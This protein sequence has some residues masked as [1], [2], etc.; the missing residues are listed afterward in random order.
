MDAVALSYWS[1]AAAA[2]TGLLFLFS[3]VRSFI[4]PL[5]SRLL[6]GL[7]VGG[8]VGTIGLGVATYVRR[9]VDVGHVP[10][11]TF[12]EALIMAALCT[13]VSFGV[14]YVV[15]GFHRVRGRS[16]ATVDI[17]GLVMC[18][19][20]NLLYFQAHT[21]SSTGETVPPVLDSPYF[22]PHV[23]VMILGYGAGITAAIMGIVFLFMSRGRSELQVETDR[24]L[25][26]IDA[27][28]YRSVMVGFPLLTAGLVLGALWANESWG[29]YWGF[30]S[31]ET[32]ALITWLCFLGYLHLRFVGGW[33][34]RRACWFLALG[35]IVI[36]I[37]FLLF[38]Y[39]PDSV[40]SSQHRYIN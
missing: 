10:T 40:A 14:I 33:R 21:R 18:A 6:H 22:I 24:G 13:E 35:G 37:T 8:L 17:F 2:G 38:G 9:W 12:W 23:S 11:Q 25:Q 20:A 5:A 27:F 3:A 1:Q 39:L 16:G 7:A 4:Q 31:K 32:W 30:D 34:N 36:F 26:S 28:C 15:N 29:T 19:V